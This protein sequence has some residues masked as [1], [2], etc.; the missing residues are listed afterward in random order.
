MLTL[1]PNG[2]EARL[3]TAETDVAARFIEA[4]P[5]IA[6]PARSAGHRAAAPERGN[7]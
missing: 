6:Q 7:A 4:R 1:G 2:L 3:A 5:A